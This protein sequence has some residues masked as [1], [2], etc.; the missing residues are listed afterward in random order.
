[1]ES[2]GTGPGI[3]ITGSLEREERWREQGRRSDTRGEGTTK[4]KKEGN[5]IHV[6]FRRA[7]TS[8]EWREWSTDLAGSSHMPASEKSFGPYALD[9]YDGTGPGETKVSPTQW[10]SPEKIG[11]QVSRKWTYEIEATMTSSGPW[12]LAMWLV[13]W[14][15]VGEWRAGEDQKERGPCWAIIWRD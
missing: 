8:S 10:K 1:M 3:R 5:S 6:L 2:V 12:E 9:S 7:C 13:L 14:A 4:L 15:A 11:K